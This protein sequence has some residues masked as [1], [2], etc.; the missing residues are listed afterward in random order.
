M[1]RNHSTWYIIYGFIIS[2]WAVPLEFPNFLP[3]LTLEFLMFLVKN[4][5]NTF[6]VL[7]NRFLVI[8]MSLLSCISQDQ[9]SIQ[10]DDSSNQFISKLNSLSLR[11]SDIKKVRIE[12]IFFI[13]S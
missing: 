2:V 6:I 7:L 8:R 9:T 10:Y 12:Y 4:I 5:C 3:I 13:F 11:L 1:E